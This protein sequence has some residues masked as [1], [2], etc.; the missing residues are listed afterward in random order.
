[1]LLATQLSVVFD[2][3]KGV[4]ALPPE[5]AFDAFAEAGFD[6]ISIAVDYR[7]RLPG[8]DAGRGL[9]RTIELA[10]IDGALRSLRTHLERRGL[11]AVMLHG[12]HPSVYD[13]SPDMRLLADVGR[14]TLRWAA[15]LGA[16]WVVFHPLVKCARRSFDPNDQEGCRKDNVL[17]FRE[18]LETSQEVGVGIAIENLPDNFNPCK[19][20]ARRRYGSIPAELIELVQELDD[21]LAGICWDTGHAQL[22]RLDQGA[23]LRAI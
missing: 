5:D 17:F 2:V 19:T 7:S 4:L 18:L 16:P 8:D 14:E 11:R 13:E 10:G 23:A 22:Q 1:M 15:I 3:E 20:G 12:P 21:P 6:G 9:Y